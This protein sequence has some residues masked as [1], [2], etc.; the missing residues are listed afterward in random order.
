MKTK[1]YYLKCKHCG[2]ENECYE[3]KTIV[4]KDG[5]YE[6]K[7]DTRIIIHCVK[8]DEVNRKVGKIFNS[9]LNK[10]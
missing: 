1:T 10:L 9:Y 3:E 2:R 4:K 6:K 5:H 7:G 8:L